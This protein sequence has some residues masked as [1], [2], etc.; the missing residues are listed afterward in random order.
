M[1]DL[2]STTTDAARGKHDFM[3]EDIARKKITTAYLSKFNKFCVFHFYIISISI[4]ERAL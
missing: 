1:W 3:V 4:F 2:Q